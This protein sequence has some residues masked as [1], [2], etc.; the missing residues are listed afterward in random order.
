MFLT[1][2]DHS[3]TSETTAKILFNKK[4]VRVFTLSVGTKEGGVIPIRDYT[5]KI[6]EYKK[7]VDGELVITR[8]KKDLLR[9]IAKEGRGAYYHLTYGG[10]AIQQLRK[11]L[12]VLEKN[13]FEKRAYTQKR[14]HY[15][16]FLLMAFLTALMELILSSRIYKQTSFLKRIGLSNESP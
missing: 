4:G 14:E 3:K 6:K 13:L 7:D 1:G 16:W 12:D 10:H 11:D 5:N 15:Q 2:E 9:K 8:L